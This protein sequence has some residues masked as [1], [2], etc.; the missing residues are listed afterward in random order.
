MFKISND[1]KILVEKIK[2]NNNKKIGIRYNFNYIIPEN[3]FTKS[4]SSN[5]K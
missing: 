3:N 2:I 1:T 4:L 5:Y